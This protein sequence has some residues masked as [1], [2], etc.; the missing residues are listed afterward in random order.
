MAFSK[1]WTHNTSNWNA[2]LPVTT[3]I[4]TA[5]R[6]NLAFALSRRL[7][8]HLSLIACNFLLSVSSCLVSELSFITH[9]RLGEGTG[10]IPLFSLCFPHPPPAGKYLVPDSPE[11][12]A[13]YTNQN[14][15]REVCFCDS[16][17]DEF[18][19]LDWDSFKQTSVQCK[20]QRQMYRE[21]ENKVNLSP[22]CWYLFI[23]KWIEFTPIIFVLVAQEDI[24]IE[25][26]HGGHVGGLKQWNS[27]T[28]K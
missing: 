17:H 12:T 7:G 4:D 18:W 26:F 6:G 20:Y 22:D 10:G 19:S 14:G 15:G 16:W 3:C 2:S 21:L 23:L 9:G 13:D 11:Q 1:L 5:G 28:W 27:F 8:L 25:C 24:A